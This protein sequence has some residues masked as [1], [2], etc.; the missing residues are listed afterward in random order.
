MELLEKLEI[1]ANSAKYDASCASSKSSISG[2][3]NSRIS[4]ICHSWSGDG[5]CISLLKI[6]LTNICEYDCRYCINRKSNNIKRTAFTVDEICYLTTEFYKRNYIEGLFLS[7][8]VMKNP[9]FTMELMIKTIKKLREEY[10][11]KGYIHIKI[12]PGSDKKLIDESIKYADRVSVNI[13]LPDSKR[14]KEICPDKTRDM[15]IKPMAY[16]KEKILE[17][18]ENKPYGGQS[19]QLII[20]ATPDSDY[21]ILNLASNLYSKLNLKRVYYSAFINVNSDEKLPALLQPPL[22]REH[23]LYQADW[24]IRL[25]KFKLNEIIN[26][27]ENLNL[28]F[29]PKTQWA[30][31]NLNFFPI[32]INKASYEEL[33]RVPGIGIYGAKKIIKARKFSNLSFEDI[34]KLRISTKKSICFLTFNGKYYGIKTDNQDRL[35]ELMTEYKQELLF[36]EN[37]LLETTEKSANIGEL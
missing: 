20:G 25:Y 2:K 5:R 6:L 31:N 36:T 37:K 8:A 1:L 13:E 7:S 28:S 34:K 10:Q 4:G 9:D 24:L 18:Y 19:T 16:A 22:L 11:F 32:E 23:R 29:D 12:I 27:D 3:G 17:R 33:I 30:L 14:F 15:I 21:N 35:K 26:R